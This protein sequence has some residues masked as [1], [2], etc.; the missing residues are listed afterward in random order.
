MPSLLSRF[1]VL[2]LLV[3]GVM[4][5]AGYASGGEEG[6]IS[7]DPM[8]HV[9]N[10]YYLDF[11]PFGKVELP[12]IFLLRTAEGKLT[13]KV[14]P[15][16]AA[17]LRSGYFVPVFEEGVE[18]VSD[19]ETLIHEG[20]HLEAHLVP[21]EGDVV[22]DLSIS[23]HVVFEFL[24]ALLL[25]WVALAV[26]ARYK[27]GIG[28]RT[29]PKGVL[30]NMMEVIVLFIRDEVA[31]P[32]IGK[33]H[34][35]F[36]PYLLTVF[37]FILFC[38]LLG[39]L[40][41]GATATANIT[42]TATLA[43]FTFLMTHLYA[44][45]DYWQHIFWPPGIPTIVRPIL[46]PVEILGM[47]TKPF[48]LAIRLFANMTAGHLVIVTLIGLIFILAGIFGTAAGLGTA[49]ISVSLALFI[50]LL[51]LLVAFI[52]AYVFTML[53]AIFIGMAVQEHH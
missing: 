9:A 47:F 22:L 1:A 13:L 7:F 53:S 35:R 8:H 43:I 23:K 2:V 42:V 12:R 49:V 27:K 39:L 37:M 52:Q 18:E 31:R 4:T 15:S 17:A 51:E 30:Q 20:H 38:N 10:A 28:R 14:Y 46:V 11:T 3:S 24:A 45:K 48:A 41:F 50:Y 32:N 25:I 6:E 44:S 16:T 36:L 40:P 29:A 33:K 34:Q 19:I 26:A 5:S 21:V